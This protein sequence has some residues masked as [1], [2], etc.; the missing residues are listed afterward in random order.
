[1]KIKIID[2]YGDEY[3]TG[4][5]YTKGGITLFMYVFDDEIVTSRTEWPNLKITAYGFIYAKDN[6]D[7]IH[8]S[9]F[10]DG[11]LYT[12]GGTLHVGPS[13][14]KINVLTDKFNIFE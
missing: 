9:F 14:F 5:G 2:Q 1:M 3:P 4:G 6:G 11:P 8:K 10:N 7:I 12:Y 13:R